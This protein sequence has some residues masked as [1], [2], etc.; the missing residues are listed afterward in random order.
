MPNLSAEWYNKYT[1]GVYKYKNSE[2]FNH[3][4]TSEKSFLDSWYYI[5]GQERNNLEYISERLSFLCEKTGLNIADYK[6]YIG[7][8][9]FYNRLTYL[10]KVS[11]S[12]K[13]LYSKENGSVDSY[14]K[15]NKSYF[16]N[17]SKE[18]I[19]YLDSIFSEILAKAI[20]LSGRVEFVI[21]GDK[22]E[23]KYARNGVFDILLKSKNKIIRYDVKRIN[24]EN[25]GL[26]NEEFI[27]NKIKDKIDDFLE[28][29]SKIDAPSF[30]ILDISDIAVKEIYSPE[31]N[32][33]TEFR[34]L[35]ED[36]YKSLDKLINKNFIIFKNWNKLGGIILISWMCA[37]N[38]QNG[39]IGTILD[40][41]PYTVNQCK[42]AN[43]YPL[44]EYTNIILDAFLAEQTKFC[45][46]FE[47]YERDLKF[48]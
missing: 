31:E 39:S 12:L 32:K 25:I 16:S 4:F 19:G 37:I 21:S 26:I 13:I 9:N 41:M 30:M 48:K 17:F 36:V 20:I 29:S 5:D 24:C 42:Y 11:D 33:F 34:V 35:K 43:Y 14:I 44:S 23:F 18:K 28:K 46:D 15:S 38:K 3:C 6:E 7:G 10:F 47:M 27:S 8:L 2:Y 40:F 1:N 22:Y 45:N